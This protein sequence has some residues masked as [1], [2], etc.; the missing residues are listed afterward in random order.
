ML[1]ASS[2]LRF[3][4]SRRTLANAPTIVSASTYVDQASYSVAAPTIWNSLPPAL[5]R[6]TVQ[7]TF[8]HH[9]KTHYFQQAFQPPSAFLLH[10]IEPTPTH[11]SARLA[12][13]LRTCGNV[14]G[15]INE[16]TLYVEPIYQYIISVCNYIHSAWPT[17]LSI[18]S[19]K[20]IE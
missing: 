14:I 11:K 18:L 7:D 16:L 1:V 6:C 4:S 10:G 15:H 5:W 2:V 19:G 17:Q 9:L 3:Q 8:H 12:V 13:L 20:V